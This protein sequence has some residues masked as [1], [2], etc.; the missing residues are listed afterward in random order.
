MNV[1]KER[2]AIIGKLIGIYREERRHNTQNEFTQKRFC[3]GICSPNTLKS[4]EAG[5]LSRFEDVYT[6]LLHKFGLK[7]DEFPAIDEAIRQVVEELYAAIEFFDRNKI[8]ILTDKMLRVLSK[9]KEYVYYS[10]IWELMKNVQKYFINVNVISDIEVIRYMALLPILSSNYSDIIKFMIFTKEKNLCSSDLKKYIKIVQSLNLHDSLKNFNRL[11][12]LHYY[13]VLNDFFS[14][15]NLILELEKKFIDDK[16]YIRLLDVYN[17]AIVLHSHVEMKEIDIFID[18]IENLVNMNSLPK[19]KT[20]EV[21][22]NIASALHSTKKYNESL[23]YY[24]KMLT[25]YNNSHINKY[26]Y[27]ADCQNHLDIAIN[28][29]IVDKSKYESYPLNVKLMYK[30]FTL[31]KD[32]PIFI[33]QN[34]IMKKILPTLVDPVFIDIFRFELNKLICITNQYKNI[35]IFDKSVNENIKRG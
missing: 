9:V 19:I 14:M 8:E 31:E 22:S 29:P 21:Y 32:V 13:F 17:Y 20:A 23:R 24:Q 2:L 3:E 6:E 1:S 25:H 28:I 15:D 12:L 18:K 7:L 30:Y 33:K 10:E 26:I 35:Y 16:N 5:G 11:L 27:M 34:Y 4:I